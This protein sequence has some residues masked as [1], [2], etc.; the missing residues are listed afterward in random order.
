MKDIAYNPSGSHFIVMSSSPRP[1]VF[2]RDGF[3]GQQFVR[4]DPY[5][6]DKQL[7]LSS[8]SSSQTIIF[9]SF[10]FF[11]SFSS[12]TKGHTTSV[13]GGQW[14][15][16]EP[17]TVL[18]WARDGTLRVW[19]INQ[20]TQNT[21]VIKLKPQMGR[22]GFVT[23]GT[24]PFAQHTLKCVISF[25]CTF[26]CKTHCCVSCIFQAATLKTGSWL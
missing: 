22:P 18:T 20:V 14:H 21:H 7:A 3:P 25:F 6:H 24:T 16:N 26:F 5:L 13:N 1:K 10:F 19:D 12:F 4:G 15:P 17:N 2:D 8:L 11:L 23:A 9:L